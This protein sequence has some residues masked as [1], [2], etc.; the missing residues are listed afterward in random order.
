MEIFN[1]K[2]IYLNL[3]IIFTKFIKSNSINI[4]SNIFRIFKKLYCLIMGAICGCESVLVIQQP[5][6]YTPP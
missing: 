2:A 1:I 3:I 6:Q 4:I 5:H